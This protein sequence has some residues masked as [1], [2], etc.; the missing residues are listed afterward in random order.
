MISLIDGA[1]ACAPSLIKRIDATVRRIYDGA[2]VRDVSVVAAELG[3]TTGQFLDLL[4]A[5]STDEART[6]AAGGAK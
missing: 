5:F 1:S 4:C 3:C 6:R 2:D